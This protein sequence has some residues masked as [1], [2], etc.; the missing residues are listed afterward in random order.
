[1]GS[2]KASYLFVKKIQKNLGEINE[3][4]FVCKHL[5][6]ACGAN[7]LYNT[8][9]V[10]GDNF[11]YIL[12][13]IRELEDKINENTEMFKKAPLLIVGAGLSAADAILLAKRH[14]IKIIHVIRRSVHDP[15]LVFK[16]LPKKSYPEYHEVYE[17]MIKYRHSSSLTKA[18]SEEEVLRPISLND[19]NNNNTKETVPVSGKAGS[20][21]DIPD[22]VLYDEHQVKYFTSKRSCKLVPLSQDSQQTGIKST[23]SSNINRHLHMQKQHHDLHNQMKTCDEEQEGT[24]VNQ[25]QETRPGTEIKICFACIL[26]GYAPDLDFLP[27]EMIDSIATD[28]S[29]ALNTKDNPIL[30]ES[31]THE[32]VMVKNLYAMGPLIGDNF[33]RFGT[34]GALAISNKIVK[35]LREEREFCSP[36][37]KKIRCPSEKLYE[38]VP[39]CPNTV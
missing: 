7:D 17:D 8:L 29:R 5:V 12:R 26:I 38:E 25:N 10:K 28:P 19:V 35:E 32:T 33:V 22:Y 18:S 16:S 15:S 14:H 36:M 9:N 21:E 4:R 23:S 24:E 11:R 30:V 20:Y 31:S 27:A 37:S 1:L 34:G 39:V 2:L 3:F 6:L 13:S